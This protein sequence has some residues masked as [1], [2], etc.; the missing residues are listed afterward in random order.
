MY[1]TIYKITNIVNSKIY[2]GQHKTDDLNDEYMGSGLRLNRAIKKYGLDNFIKEILYVFDNE[3]DMNS[4]EKELVNEEYINSGKTYNLCPGG[5][6]GFGYIN[7]NNL[8]EYS[9]NGKKGRVKSNQKLELLYGSDYKTLMGKKAYEKAKKHP[10]WRKYGFSNKIHTEETR[11]K[12][13]KA[14]SLHQQGLKNSQY[15]TCWITN[16]TENKKI[17]KEDLDSYI[18]QGYYKGRKLL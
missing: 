3:E 2:I 9:T 7:Q 12:I 4:K 13:G 18:Q 15:G 5:K 16:G 1:Y 11:K 17:R 10:N 6:G 14:N 8:C